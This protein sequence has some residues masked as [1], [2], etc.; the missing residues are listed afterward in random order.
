MTVNERLEQNLLAAKTE[1]ETMDLQWDALTQN[2][3]L[4]HRLATFIG[5]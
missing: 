4:T 3:I 2:E 1:I 5:V